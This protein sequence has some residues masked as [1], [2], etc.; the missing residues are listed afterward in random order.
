MYVGGIMVIICGLIQWVP[1][2]V[3][4]LLISCSLSTGISLDSQ[5]I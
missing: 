4:N 5:F 1:T 2:N 3:S